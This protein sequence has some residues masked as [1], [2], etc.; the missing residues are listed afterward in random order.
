VFKNANETSDHI[1]LGFESTTFQLSGD[2]PGVGVGVEKIEIKRGQPEGRRHN[3]I[4]LTRLPNGKHW[5]KEH[6]F[7]YGELL[8]P[9]G[10][11]RNLKLVGGEPLLVKETVNMIEYLANE[12]APEKLVLSFTTNGTVFDDRFFKTASRFK[13]VVIAVSLDGVGKLFEYIRHGAKWST[14]TENLRRFSEIENSII[15]ISAT[16]QA[17]NALAFTDLLRFCDQQGYK[18]LFNIL[19]YP[20]Y[21]AAGILPPSARQ[22]AAERLR[23]YA[24]HEKTIQNKQQ[25]LSAATLL[26][27]AGSRI[28]MELLEK[29]MLFSNDLDTSRRESIGDVA[30]EILDHLKHSN[31]SWSKKTVFA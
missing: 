5:L 16:F 12:G 8:N 25:I 13:K 30:P 1:T 18:I 24:R 23:T 4:L 21:L 2:S 3:N 20:S 10:D 29:F 7:L 14:V 22:L 19:N 9:P 11:I 17:Y 15:L 31:I 6:S 27:S 26:E 28:D